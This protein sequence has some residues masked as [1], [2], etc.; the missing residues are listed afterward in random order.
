MNSL[1]SVMKSTA[2]GGV[3]F[4]LP[5]VLMVV[6]VAKALNV[7]GFIARPIARLIPYDSLA[8]YAVVDLLAIA[9]LF[10]VTLLAGALARSS[11]FDGVH[12]RLDAVMLQLFPGYSWI[13]GMTGSLSD[14]DAEKSLKSVAVIQDDIVQ[15]GYEVE[16]LPDNWVAVFLP[17]APDTRSGGVGFFAA[18]RVVPLDA[19][20]ASIAGCL[21]TLGVG[22][23]EIINVQ[24]LQRNAQS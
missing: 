7:I 8:G 13:K 11:L 21:K 2:V 22:S 6:L 23:S 4:L 16:R 18:D 5:V 3:V 10:L 20:F 14:A 12:Q 15:I 1:A 9:L 19:T 17:G 24:R